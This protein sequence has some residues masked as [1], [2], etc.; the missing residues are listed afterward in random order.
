MGAGFSS[1]VGL[2][3]SQPRVKTHDRRYAF[4]L[5]HCIF[6]TRQRVDSLKVI[7]EEQQVVID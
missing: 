7:F 5:R 3:G 6:S 4:V 2:S 1:L